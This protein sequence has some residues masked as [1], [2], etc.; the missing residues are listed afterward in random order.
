MRANWYRPNTVAN[1]VSGL[2]SG[3]TGITL[4]TDE[5]SNVE[6]NVDFPKE[7]KISDMLGQG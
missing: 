4:Y 1:A 6:K 7:L 3:E 5:T 2:D